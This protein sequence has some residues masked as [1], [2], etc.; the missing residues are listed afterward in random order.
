MP[1]ALESGGM[2][3]AT[4]R[5]IGAL[6]ILVYLPL[7]VMIAATLGGM[8]GGDMARLAFYA[9]AGFAWVIPL[10]PLFKWMRE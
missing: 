6:A 3:P 1:Q 9:V 2:K 5:A 4:R 7:Y 8:I 10:Y